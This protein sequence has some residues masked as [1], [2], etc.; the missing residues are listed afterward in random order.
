MSVAKG[1]ISGG[2][3][4]DFYGS[5]LGVV[6]ADDIGATLIALDGRQYLIDVR[7]YQRTILDSQAPQSDDAAEPGEKSLSRAGYWARAQEDWRSG[8]GQELFDAPDSSRA[9]F[10]SSHGVEVFDPRKLSLL[11]DTALRLGSNATNLDVFA[12]GGYLYFV[13]GTFLR[14]TNDPDV[15]T[16]TFTSVNHTN[17]IVDWTTDGARI[18][19][20]FGGAV[21]PNVTPVGS[22]AAPAAFGATTPDIIEYANGRLVAADGATLFELDNAG[23]KPGGANIRVDPRTG[24]AWAAI[25]GAPSAIFAALNIGDVA[26]VYAV[27]VTDTGTNLAAPTYAG[28]LPYGETIRCMA[29]YPPGRVVIIGTSKG[30]RVAVID[31]VT[32]HIGERIDVPGGVNALD[33]RDKFCWFTWTD[34]RIGVTGLGRVDLSR[35]T[36]D[37]T[38][39]PAYAEDLVAAVTGAVTGVASLRKTGGSRER[40]YFVVSKGAAGGGLYAETDDLVEQGTLESGHVRFGILPDKIFTSVEIRHEQAAGSVGAAVTFDD[41]SSAFIGGGETSGGTRMVLDAAGSAGLSASLALMLTRDALDATLGPTVRAWVLSA[42][43]RPPRV[44]EF[45]L[46]IVL[47]SKV[48]DLRQNDRV[49][50]PLDEVRFFE[51]LA[52][53]SRLVILQMGAESRR[54]RVASVAVPEGAVRAWGQDGEW[55]EP[56]AFVRLLSKEN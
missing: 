16:P 23:A 36:S 15:A 43:P 9:R 3:S 54:V 14:H 34:T 5:S 50:E 4:S 11:H 22:G 32:L 12:V 53:S 18:Y 17:A 21:V 51:G 52:S 41:G 49:Y 46:P 6:S 7:Q 2:L 39:V 33:L 13:D 31:G 35:G 55:F 45:I 48:T 27:T 20:V 38:F 44:T 30:L 56:I 29:A 47:S 26:E 37:A 24:A 10:M 40:R 28:G 42:L 8:A 19:T 1:S 25:T